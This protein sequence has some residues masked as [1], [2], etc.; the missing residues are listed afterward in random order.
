M[1]TDA[2][3]MVV[4]GHICRTEGVERAQKLLHRAVDAL[5]PGG[6]LIL[7]D[8][9]ADKERKHNPFGV[10]MGLTMLANTESGRMLTHEQVYGWLQTMRLEAIRLI[11][12]IGFNQVYVGTKISQPKSSA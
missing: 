8:Y 9:F 2:Y 1:E 10:Q 6:K 5:V 11:E 7:A 3:D 12:P 4:L